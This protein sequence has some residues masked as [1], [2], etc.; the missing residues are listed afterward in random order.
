[1]SEDYYYKKNPLI[2]VTFQIRFN[3]ILDLLKSPPVDFQKNLGISDF[4]YSEIKNIS[5]LPD[6]FTPTEATLHRFTSN[7]GEDNVF[8]VDLCADYLNVAT[9]SYINF[10]S[11]QSS[12]EQG[13]KALER[14]YPI[15]KFSRLGFM[16]QNLIIREE[17]DLEQY[18]WKELLNKELAP[19][20][21]EDFPVKNLYSFLKVYSLKESEY[22]FTCKNGLV[23][24]INQRNQERT[25]GYNIDIDGYVLGDYTYDTALYHTRKI[26][27]I[28]KQLFRQ[29]ITTKLHECLQPQSN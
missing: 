26:R 24:V 1:M 28:N 10:A 25:Q 7:K 21:F 22:N 13:L 12:I 29:F 8:N 20:L 17:I 11:F 15:K 9:S 27:A 16:Y 14:S 18:E 19:E 5:L 2:Q 4:D 23:D 3:R 6:G